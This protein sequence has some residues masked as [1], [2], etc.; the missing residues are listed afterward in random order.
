MTI[1][2][3]FAYFE[4]KAHF[5]P[6]QN[7]LKKECVPQERFSG[8]TCFLIG[9]FLS[10]R[11]VRPTAADRG[12]MLPSACHALRLDTCLPGRL[13]H[14]D[15]EKAR[16]FPCGKRA[17]RTV[18]LSH[19]VSRPRGEWFSATQPFQEAKGMEDRQNNA[20][21]HEKARSLAKRLEFGPAPF[22][23]GLVVA[24]VFGWWIFPELLFSRQDQP[25]SS[26]MR[27]IL[28]MLLW[29]VRS[30]TISVRT[31]RSTPCPLQRT[32]LSAI[33]RCSAKARPNGSSSTNTSR[34]AR[35]WTG[36][37]TRSSLTT[38]SSAMPCTRWQPVTTVMSSPSGSFA[39]RAISTWLP[40]KSRPC[41][42]RTGSPATARTP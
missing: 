34:R 16:P 4:K 33:R 11:H 2:T 40:A 1:L 14:D 5:G 22:I 36:K 20:P 18:F 6:T 37:S 32:V 12:H 38:C 42:A 28:R 25:C 23:V 30:V 8:T 3:E 39:P 7:I 10:G 35:K 19:D 13:H 9:R 31:G 21:S 29:T 26:A 24:L 41:S 27:R 17:P 15:G